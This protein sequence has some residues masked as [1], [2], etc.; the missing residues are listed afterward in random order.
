V[1][2]IKA[3]KRGIDRQKAV[4]LGRTKAGESILN[5]IREHPE[6]GYDF[7]DYIE[8]GEGLS[9]K[10]KRLGVETVFV[11]LPDVSREDLIE[12]VTECKWINFKII[13]DL[14]EIISEP[15]SFDEFR[16]LP[17][18]TVR[19]K[20]GVLWYS[21]YIKRL[22][23]VS[24]SL[25]LLVFLSPLMVSTALAIKLDS[26]GPVFFRQKRVG[27]GEALFEVVKY[28]T[29]KED[30]QEIRDGLAGLN[31]VKGLFKM[32]KDP[33][34]T[35]VGYILRRTCID[36]LPQLFNILRGDMSLVGPRPHIPE[37]MPYFNGWRR[38][39]FSVK[40][41]LTGL[42][43]ISGRHEIDFDKAVLMDLYYIKHMSFFLDMKILIK[44][45][46][47]I[48]YSRGRW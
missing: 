37:E 19:G 27:E 31:E 26:R 29:M 48:I 33:R 39:R 14:V 18:I 13:P 11:A 10:L 15:L 20:G 3:R 30:A 32:H 1:V 21:R 5:K 34:V 23:D 8:L 35:R 28:R 38:N 4:I 36:E 42:W 6:L 24:A 22:L 2:L 47:S 12:L 44:T 17:L 16:D 46:P 9:G 41:G 40:P 25:L 7:V 45:I 43:Q